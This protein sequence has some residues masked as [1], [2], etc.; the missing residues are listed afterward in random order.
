M[1]I[2]VKARL[3][4]EEKK[5]RRK[6]V[7]HAWYLKNREEQISRSLERYYD[8]QEECKTAARE[9]AR[10]KAARL[11]ELERLVAQTPSN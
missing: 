4:D 2:P 5:A 1:E 7:Q 10:A 9:R 3:T 11:Q 6:A 8:N